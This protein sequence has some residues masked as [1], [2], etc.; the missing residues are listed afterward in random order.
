[1]GNDY[2]WYKNVILY[3]LT[4]SVTLTISKEEA[5]IYNKFLLICNHHG[6]VTARIIQEIYGL[7][8]I[9]VIKV[10]NNLA[11]D[12][13]ILEKEFVNDETYFNVKEDFLKDMKQL[14]EENIYF[15]APMRFSLSLF[16]LIVSNKHLYWEKVKDFE[17]N[18]LMFEY[19]ERI[20][21]IVQS[22]GKMKKD[23]EIPDKICG[24]NFTKGIKINGITHCWIGWKEN[25]FNLYQ[26]N[27][28]ISQI[29]NKH[30]D[31]IKLKEEI[32]SLRTNTELLEEK[33]NQEI[34]LKLHMTNFFIEFNEN[35]QDLI[36]NIEEQDIDNL[37]GIYRTVSKN[38]GKELSVPLENGW[39]FK[40]KLKFKISDPILNTWILLMKEL[41]ILIK[42][43]YL[44]LING[45][46]SSISSRIDL[47]INNIRNNNKIFE[48]YPSNEDIQ[49]NIQK[50]ANYS[51]DGWFHLIF[52]K[53][54]EKEVIR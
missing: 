52:A 40:I 7:D 11:D 14:E 17:P 41:N 50:V 9:I 30:P 31:F 19:L 38:E 23:I 24:F 26:N 2:I 46:I 47:L 13:R 8:E 35:N 20:D 4:C 10:L 32:E 18:E 25:Q 28:K 44:D 43:K 33:V 37:G 42:D 5:E 6:K 54:L 34:T 45:D 3:N 22:K 27:Y 53:F 36:I 39:F 49:T 21:K 15:Q 1:M 12:L 29:L 48:F 16:P 51:D